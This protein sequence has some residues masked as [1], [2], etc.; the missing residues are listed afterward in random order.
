MW[1]TALFPWSQ[2][3]S[4]EIL[5]GLIALYEGSSIGEVLNIKTKAPVKGNTGGEIQ[6]HHHSYGSL[7]TYDTSVTMSGRAATWIMC[8]G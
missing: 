4:I 3:E 1:I 5:P 2:I 8:W 7:N 6:Y